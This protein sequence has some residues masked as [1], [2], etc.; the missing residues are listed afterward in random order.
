M[1]HTQETG[2]YVSEYLQYGGQAVIEG[3]MMRSPRYYAVACRAPD[4]RIVVATEPVS[5]SATGRR[6]WLNKP[7]ARGTLALLD[8][9]SLGIRALTFSARI[10]ADALGLRGGAAEDASRGSAASYS[11]GAGSVKISDIAIGTTIVSA[12]AM[13]LALFVALPT[14]VTQLVQGRLGV[15]APLALNC[16]DGFVRIVIFFGYVAAIGRMENIRRVFEYHGAE[17]KAI[18]AFEAGL[19][20]NLENALKCS[21]IHPRC[22]TSFIVVVLIAG[23]IV[24]S[25]LPRPQNYLLRLALHLGL[26][27]VVAGIAYEV[28]RWAG[29]TRDA[30]LT[31]WLLAP[32]LWSQRLTTREPHADQVEVALAALNAVIRE[33]ASRGEVNVAGVA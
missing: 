19:E 6:A 14:L 15:T 21:R 11:G 2:A 10:Q 32:G 17:H 1:P 4:G 31:R 26:V 25:L 16:M 3:V 23:I 22:G 28:I 18:N 33:E 9:M 7:L 8:A 30:A 27:P 24:Q 12:I 13:G 29:R 5:S 20:L